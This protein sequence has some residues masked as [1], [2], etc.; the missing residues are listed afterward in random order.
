M[1]RYGEMWR[2]V[3]DWV[4]Y[5]TTDK[6]GLVVGWAEPPESKI[7]NWWT[8]TTGRFGR[9]GQRSPPIDWRETME[10]RPMEYTR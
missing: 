6:D 3:P 8:P 5:I 10:S 1:S 7:K 4:E 9:V 2:N